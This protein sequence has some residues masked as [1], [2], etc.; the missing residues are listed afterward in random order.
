M[1]LANTFLPTAGMAPFLRTLADWNPVSAFVAA[2]RVLF[3]N[4]G[5]GTSS[6]WP[7]Q[8]PIAASL[9]WIV[10][11]VAVFLPLGVRCYREAT[12]A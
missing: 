6:A 11:L 12:S 7:M 4:P 5:V 10:V 9:S 2:C 3:G 1:F 8:H